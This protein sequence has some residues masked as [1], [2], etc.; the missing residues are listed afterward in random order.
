MGLELGRIDERLSASKAFDAFCEF[1]QV[2]PDDIKEQLKNAMA[3]AIDQ[4]C[5]NIEELA[6]KTG[7]D[8]GN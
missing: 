8:L 5:Q 3:P 2:D 4:A 7:A 6:E 1:S